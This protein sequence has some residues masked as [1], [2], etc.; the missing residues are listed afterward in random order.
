VSG[1]PSHFG[2]AADFGGRLGLATGVLSIGSGRVHVP[3]DAFRGDWPPF[4]S[5]LNPYQIK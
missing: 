5:T 3:L 2:S 1:E 4:A